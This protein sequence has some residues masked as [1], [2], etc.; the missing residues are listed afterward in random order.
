MNK[1][2]RSFS[3]GQLALLT[4]ATVE[5]DESFII[6]GATDLHSAT[7]SEISFLAASQFLPISYEQAVASSQAGAI[8]LSAKGAFAQGKHCL[9]HPDPSR[10]FQ[11]ILEAF[12][13]E[14]ERS[15]AFTSIHPT[16]VIHPS[17]IISP[18]AI[19]APYVV[20]DQNASIGAKT[21]I[22]AHCYVGPGATIGSEC[23]LYP[24]V[25]I[26]ENCSLG[27][28]VIIQP[29]ACIGSCGF[30]YTTDK[31]GTH[32]KLSQLGTVEIE[33]EVEIGANATID[34][35]RFGKTKIGKGTKI[36]NGVQIAHGVTVGPHNL[37]AAHVAIAGSTKT[38]SHVVMG[39]QVGVS[40]HIEIAS[41]TM[42]AAQ[43]GVAKSIESPGK[44]AGKH[45]LPLTQY[46]RNKVLLR[47]IKKTIKETIKEMI[48]KEHD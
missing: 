32:T 27:D 21:K 41:G 10:A 28:R 8:V 17:A 34:R 48:G 12:F 46:N 18:D 37:F 2:K 30:G 15:S 20:I 44:Y 1:P 43:S 9:L 39:G 35:A 14:E 4:G 16:A 3:L 26:R 23:L 33:D 13:P 22:G 40:G 42:I 47:D 45:L 29:G 31:Q 6:T 7:F 38:G 36:D 19:I 5:G 24:H 11:H 25:T